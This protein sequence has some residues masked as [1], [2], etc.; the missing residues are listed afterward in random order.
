M[1]LIKI[2]AIKAHFLKQKFIIRPKVEVSSLDKQCKNKNKMKSIK[3]TR[4]INKSLRSTKILKRE[5]LQ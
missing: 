2:H 5:I 1:T 3:S 4:L